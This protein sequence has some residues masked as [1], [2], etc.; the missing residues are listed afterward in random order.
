MAMATERSRRSARAKSPVKET[1]G[2]ELSSESETEEKVDGGSNR[3]PG[4]SVTAGSCGAVAEEPDQEVC[5]V[6]AAKGQKGFNIAKRRKEN[7]SYTRTGFLIKDL[8]DVDEQIKTILNVIK[9]WKELYYN[10]K[11]F[12]EIKSGGGDVAAKRL[13]K[14]S[15]LLKE[16]MTDNV[17]ISKQSSDTN[18]VV[19]DDMVIVPEQNQT[20]NPKKANNPSISYAKAL[21]SLPMQIGDVFIGKVSNLSSKQLDNG[22]VSNENVTI[23]L[24]GGNGNVSVTD[25]ISDVF[26]VNEN[27]SSLEE[28]VWG[29][30]K[31][32]QEEVEEEEYG[33]RKNAVKI[34]WVGKREKFPDVYAMMSITDTEFDLSFKLSQGLEEFWRQYNF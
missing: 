12:D 14:I 9:P 19:T 5:K 27:I 32:F 31:L 30:K 6:S 21:I 29:K 7:K 16:I 33:K 2:S 20:S 24:S 18:T 4:A 34:K 1:V 8:E 22:L 17:D 15:E 26:C 23:T 25:K 3:V 28:S 11:S 10:K 13:C